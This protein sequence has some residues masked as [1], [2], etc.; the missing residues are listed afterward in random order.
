MGLFAAKSD[1][2]SYAPPHGFEL[3]LGCCD[4][5]ASDDVDRAQSLERKCLS[6][7]NTIGGASNLPRH[8]TSDNRPMQYCLGRTCRWLEWIAHTPLESGA[9]RWTPLMTAGIATRTNRDNTASVCISR[10]ESITC[11]AQRPIVPVNS[12]R[13][14]D[15]KEEQRCCRAF[16]G[17][18]CRRSCLQAEPFD[19]DAQA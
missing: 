3:G 17:A 18:S 16:A 9:R 1:G 15:V 12:S 4:S 2:A 11:Q 6:V 14:Y 8:C 19:D 5:A 10:K 7:G 13:I